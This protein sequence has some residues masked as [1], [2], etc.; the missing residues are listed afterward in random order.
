M[1]GWVFGVALLISHAA[2]GAAPV[3]QQ[4][5][6]FGHVIGDL[7][8]QRVLLEES[9]RPFEPASLPATGPTGVWLERRAARIEV[10]SHGRRWLALDY[11]ILNTP[12]A[13][14]VVPLPALKIA[15]KT[16]RGELRV[17][18]WPISIAPLSPPRGFPWVGMGTLRPERT[19]PLIDVAPI[20]RGLAFWLTAFVTL[21]V[22]WLAW[23]LWR[24]WLASANQPFGVALRELRGV[25][26][27]EPRAWHALHRA[28]DGT[29]GQVVRADALAVLFQRAP[30]MESLRARIERFYAQ[31]AARFFGTPADGAARDPLSLHQLCADL[32]RIEKGRE[33]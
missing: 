6:S 2:I 1:R 29:A 24:N 8:T 31:S 21:G 33:T 3:V 13:L 18:E 10:D 11:Q 14:Q 17:A 22:A 32:R 5:R 15:A 7:F 4:P 25:D 30:E 27:N 12:Q 16:G 26:E 23:W 20:Q 9:G 28:F 19:A